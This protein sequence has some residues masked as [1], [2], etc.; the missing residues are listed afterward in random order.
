MDY[1]LASDHWAQVV[2]DLKDSS[3]NPYETE[4]LAQDILRY[5]RYTRFRQ[6]ALFSQKR[7]EEFEKMMEKLAEKYKLEEIQRVIS[8]EDFWTITLEVSSA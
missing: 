6:Y 3:T 5:A 4:R 7:G 1:S 2:R 8:D